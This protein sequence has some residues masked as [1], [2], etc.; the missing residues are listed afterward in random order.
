MRFET[1]LARLEWAAIPN[2]PGRY[3]LRTDRA[4]IPP[5][6]LVG[7]NASTRRCHSPHAADPIELVLLEDGALLSYRKPNGRYVHTLNT[8]EGLAR[9]LAQLELA[10]AVM[11]D[12]GTP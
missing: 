4:T 9:K 10:Q 6:R 3:V 1:L 8:P 7:E 5:E 12:A 2:C 11:G